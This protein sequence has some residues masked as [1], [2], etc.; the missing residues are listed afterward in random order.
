MASDPAPHVRRFDAF[1]VGDWLA[2]PSLCRLSRPGVSLRLRPQLM[3]LLVCLASR[4]GRVVLKD[5]FHEEVWSGQIVAESSL[6]RCMAELRQALGDPVQRPQYIDTIPKRGYR[7]IA[8]VNF[9]ECPMSSTDS[10]GMAIAP[11]EPASPK[12]I[13]L[14]DQAQAAPPDGSVGVAGTVEQRPPAWTAIRL[15]VAIAGVLLVAVIGAAT[16]W[17]RTPVVLA[18]TLNLILYFEN[19]TDEAALTGALQHALATQLEQSPLLRVVPE[20]DVRQILRTMGRPP[21]APL[22]PV[23]AREVC[24]RDGAKATVVGS[25][26]RLGN[27]YVLAIEATACRTGDTVVRELMSV[28]KREDVLDG[29]G[30]MALRVRRALGESLAAQHDVDRVRNQLLTPA[31][32]IGPVSPE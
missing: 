27:S 11:E 18:D 17:R 10:S 29:L 23:L 16:S 15:W 6:P 12:V 3:D 30:T 24:T 21:D 8:P 2:E 5:E 19:H 26:A 22:T 4:A 13:A 7:L 32:I 1:H 14:S 20:R 25:I 31:G 28:N 9:V